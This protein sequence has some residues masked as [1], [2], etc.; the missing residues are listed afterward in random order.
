MRWL[1]YALGGGLG[2]LTRS[3]A[4]ARAA[5][6]RG[7]Q[8]TILTNS[9]FAR[10]LPVTNELNL[11]DRL[12]IIPP[13]F[14]REATAARIGAILTEIEFDLLVVDTFPRG[15]GGELVDILPSVVVPKALVHRDLNPHYVESYQLSE[16]V[17][18]YDCLL[19]PGESG[20][21]ESHP[22]AV[23]TE[24]WLIRDA[25]ELLPRSAARHELLGRVADDIP[26]VL[27]MGS[28]RTEEID[29]MHQLADWLRER[30]VT[31]AHVCFSSPVGD[32]DRQRAAWPVFGLYAGVDVLIGAGGYNTVSEARATQTPLLA[33]ARQR[34]YD[35]QQV[36]LT[37]LEQV[38]D[39]DELLLRLQAT[40]AGTQSPGEQIDFRNGT[41]QAIDVL[42]ALLQ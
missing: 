38:A 28:G 22:A 2:H 4:L 37:E 11:A 14:D 39:R 19:L 9:P 6:R 26:I 8:C 21:L 7:V 34:L 32:E 18:S 27:V 23:R 42:T 25:D 17:K 5:G 40:L 24:P 33:F 35:R 29:Q 41:H 1:I 30:L 10:C 20:P 15:L 36:R 12:I 16:F 3:V 13:E 31:Q